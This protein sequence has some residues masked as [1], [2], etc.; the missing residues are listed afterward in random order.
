MFLHMKMRDKFQQPFE[1]LCKFCLSF[2]FFSQVTKNSNFTGTA[3]SGFINLF[4][5]NLNVNNCYYCPD[6]YIDVSGFVRSLVFLSF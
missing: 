3:E 5:L 1:F 6:N 4:N 2:D